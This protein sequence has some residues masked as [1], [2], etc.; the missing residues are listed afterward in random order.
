MSHDKFED[1]FALDPF[2]EAAEM[3]LDFHVFTSADSDVLIY[4]RFLIRAIFATTNPQTDD[5]RRFAEK[6]FETCMRSGLFFARTSSVVPTRLVYN[7]MTPEVDAEKRLK[8]LKVKDLM[9]VDEPTEPKKPIPAPELGPLPELDLDLGLGGP[10]KQ[11][12]NKPCYI[13]SQNLVEVGADEIPVCPPCK[14]IIRRDE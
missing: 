12:Q 5:V 1:W 14:D 11:V 2:Q 7:S 10:F 4:L 8:E 6:E 3:R 13:C 9:G